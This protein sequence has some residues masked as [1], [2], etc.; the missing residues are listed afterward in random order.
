MVS[1]HSSKTLTKA[2][3]HIYIY[4]LCVCVCVCCVCVGGA[5]MCHKTCADIR[6][7]LAEVISLFLSHG[8]WEL[9]LGH[10]V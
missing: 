7:Q 1:V 8:S 3:M 6:E 9:N 10:R 4:N 2:Y 5:Y